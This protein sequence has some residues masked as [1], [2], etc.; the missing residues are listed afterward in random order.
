MLW[1][2]EL[3]CRGAWRSARHTVKCLL[4]LC[5]CSA[6]ADEP[7]GFLLPC[8]LSLATAPLPG[9]G[10]PRATLLLHT[11]TGYSPCPPKG[12]STFRRYLEESLRDLPSVGFPGYVLYHLSLFLYLRDTEVAPRFCSQQPL[13]GE[14]LSF[15]D[16][17]FSGIF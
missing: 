6:N 9:S 14:T 3:M 13:S 8:L 4:L 5:S 11:V 15:G 12:A 1:L 2:N 17:S 7:R 16:T 10:E